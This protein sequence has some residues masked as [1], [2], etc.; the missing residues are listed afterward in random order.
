MRQHLLLDS[1]RVISLAFADSDFVAERMVT[2]ASILS[3]QSRFI[4]PIIGRALLLSICEGH[5]IE[6]LEEYVAPALAEYVR[7]EITP[8]SDPHRQALLRRA[9]AMAARLSDHLDENQTLYLEYKPS[10][11][12][13]HKISIHGTII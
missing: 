10:N 11:N 4:E 7:V 6:L 1:E 8:Q 2:P 12:I 5:Y 3:A 9:R 13:L